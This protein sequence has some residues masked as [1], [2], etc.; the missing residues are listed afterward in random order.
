MAR[1]FGFDFEYESM[2]C[3]YRWLFL[4]SIEGIGVDIACFASASRPSL[5]FPEFR[6]F[7]S[8]AES[9]LFRRRFGTKISSLAIGNPLLNRLRKSEA[10]VEKQVDRPGVPKKQPIE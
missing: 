6:L 10:S 7:R 3:F 5:L 1:H 4:I 9:F 8:F 2:V